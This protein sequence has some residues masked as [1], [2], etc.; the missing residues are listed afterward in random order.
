MAIATWPQGHSRQ[1]EEEDAMS[2]SKA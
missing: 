2:N 1:E